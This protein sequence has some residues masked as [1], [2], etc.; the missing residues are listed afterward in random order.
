MNA[1]GLIEVAAKSTVAACSSATI[2]RSANRQNQPISV[3]EFFI[4][5][6][7]ATIRSP[8]KRGRRARRHGSEIHLLVGR[9][10]QEHYGQEPQVVM[11]IR[12]SRASTAC[13]K[14]SKSLATMSYHRCPS[15]DMFGQAHVDLDTLM[16]RYYELLSLQ[17][18]G[19]FSSE[20]GG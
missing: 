15:G 18:T 2:F 20:G 12:C 1:A 19:N 13:R 16:W 4:R 3:H 7:R 11:T 5:W 10:L 9:Q 17:S 8:S 6:C 14:M